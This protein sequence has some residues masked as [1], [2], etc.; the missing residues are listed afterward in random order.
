LFATEIDSS[1]RLQS[2]F[3]PTSFNSSIQYDASVI[4]CYTKFVAFY[5]ATVAEIENCYKSKRQREDGQLRRVRAERDEFLLQVRR[6][7]PEIV[8]WA[9]DKRQELIVAD[10][11]Q[12]RDELTNKRLQYK[13]IIEFKSRSQSYDRELQRQRCKNLQRNQ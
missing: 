3:V 1:N 6:R 5:V 7:T 12:L 8:S 10:G 2:H 4:A 11:R 13:S 9:L